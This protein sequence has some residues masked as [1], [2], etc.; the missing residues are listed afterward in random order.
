MVGFLVKTIFGV[1]PLH[2]ILLPGYRGWKS[3]FS[4]GQDSYYRHRHLEGA[5]GDV[6]SSV[7]AARESFAEACA[8]L[9]CRPDRNEPPSQQ[10]TVADEDGGSHTGETILHDRWSPAGIVL[11]RQAIRQGDE[12]PLRQEGGRGSWTVLSCRDGGHERML[13]WLFRCPNH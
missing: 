12:G 13:S 11:K 1:R 8:L 9:P 2:T 7:H 5:T 10:R 4:G 6:N 3:L